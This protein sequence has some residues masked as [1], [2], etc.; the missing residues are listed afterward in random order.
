M[1]PWLTTVNRAPP[2]AVV[3]KT[4]ASAFSPTPCIA[5]GRLGNPIVLDREGVGP[6]L[7]RLEAN[8]TD[9]TFEE[10]AKVGGQK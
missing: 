2:A 5:L 6:S 4:S 10:R 7:V 8:V 3:I 9:K 1:R